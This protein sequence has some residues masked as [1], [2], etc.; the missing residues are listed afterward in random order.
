MQAKK[1]DA[2][3]KLHI[4]LIVNTGQVPERVILDTMSPVQLMLD[5]LAPAAYHR[6]AGN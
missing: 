2:R 1:V 6:S 4:A 3:R 5:P